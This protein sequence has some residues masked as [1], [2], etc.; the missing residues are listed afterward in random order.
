[1]APAAAEF[2]RGW[3]TGGDISA[4]LPGALTSA[5]AGRIPE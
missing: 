5:V 3:S 2:A 1:M 4:T